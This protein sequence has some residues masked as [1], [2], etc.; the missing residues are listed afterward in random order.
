MVWR[1]LILISW[2]S[3]VVTQDRNVAGRLVERCMKRVDSQCKKMPSKATNP[4][5]YLYNLT[6]HT[7]HT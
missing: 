4:S 5:S 6:T 3:I 1:M 2:K 7:I